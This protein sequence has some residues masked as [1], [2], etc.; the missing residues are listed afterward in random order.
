M[1]AYVVRTSS[2]NDNHSGQLFRIILW[3][4]TTP[5][6]TIPLFRVNMSC[7]V[8]T[9]FSRLSLVSSSINMANL[10]RLVCIS[11]QFCSSVFFVSTANLSY[12]LAT[13]LSSLRFLST[14]LSS[15]RFKLLRMAGHC[16]SWFSVFLFS[17]LNLSLSFFRS[18]VSEGLFALS[19]SFLSESFFLIQ[20]YS[21]SSV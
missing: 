12:L 20:C 4:K 10:S 16:F 21:C 13:T 3:D 2:L 14:S 19:F 15:P 1:C 7:A 17:R 8:A 11:L 6:S 18:S 9:I 5:T